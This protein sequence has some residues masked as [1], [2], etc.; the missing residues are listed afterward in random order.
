L[1]IVSEPDAEGDS[2]K[3][4]IE[5]NTPVVLETLHVIVQVALRDTSVGKIKALA[6]AE[7]T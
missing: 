2:S 5:V 1:T 6:V 4:D 7:C 3:V